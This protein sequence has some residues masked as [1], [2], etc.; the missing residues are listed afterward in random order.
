M[1]TLEKL[2]GLYK[3]IRTVLPV[4]NQEGTEISEYF[5][6]SLNVPSVKENL[7][8][9][10][11][12]LRT[13]NYDSILPNKNQKLEHVL[14][15]LPNKEEGTKIIVYMENDEIKELITGLSITYK[16]SKKQQV[17]KGLSGPAYI[18]VDDL[19][20]VSAELL[21]WYKDKR[22]NT[23]TKI[24]ECIV[25]ANINYGTIIEELDKKLK[26]IKG[27]QK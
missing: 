10:S 5:I 27:T 26:R 8:Y 9:F 12:V 1:A 22:K 18:D 25:Q 2:I 16:N 6:V 14:S 11:G 19:I 15:L 3:I 24:N 17:H 4:E 23:R 7:E 20:P 21:T 13:Q